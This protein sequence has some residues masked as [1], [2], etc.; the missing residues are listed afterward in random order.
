LAQ[1][2]DPF[3]RSDVVLWG[4]VAVVTSALALVAANLAAFVPEDALAV[5]HNSRAVTAQAGELTAKL[6]ALDLSKSKL[7][8]L[9]DLQQ[10]VQA[11]QQQLTAARQHVAA[12]EDRLEKAQQQASRTADALGVRLAA[13]ERAVAA[14]GTQLSALAEAAPRK[15]N[16]LSFGGSDPTAITGAIDAPVAGFTGATPAAEPME[17]PMPAAL[18]TVEAGAV[19]PEWTDVAALPAFTSPANPAATDGA[20]PDEITPAEATAAD[21]PI[22]YPM[23]PRPATPERPATAPLALETE[24]GSGGTAGASVEAPPRAKPGAIG[25]P[26][27][28]R[29][30][31]DVRAIGVAVGSPTTPAA[32]LASWQQIAERVGVLLV[33]TSPLLAADPAGSSGKVLVAGPIPSI[34]AATALCGKI[35]AAALSCMPM[36]YVGAA[37]GGEE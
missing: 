29:P 37:L 2:A 12:V 9:S 15:V 26:P 18:P 21:A 10:Q 22:P 23:A 16:A 13:L 7:A 8:E 11:S 1:R 34:A 20:V 19:G 25:P 36:P 6:A 33:G 14:N 24:P 35:E 5:L 32:A 30:K 31:A 4:S 27:A 3:R 28:R 17:Q